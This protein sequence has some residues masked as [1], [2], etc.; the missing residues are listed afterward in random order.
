MNKQVLSP[1]V[2]DMCAMIEDITKQ[3]IEVTASDT[4]IRLSWAQ[5]G[6]DG[7]DTPEAQ[8]IEALKQAIRGRLGDRFIEFF[9]A[10]GIQ[11]VY[12]KYDPEEYPEEMR[13]R[14]VG[15]DATA[16]T[17]Y[18]RTLLEVDAIQVRRD[19]LDDLLRFT[20]GGIIQI[21][22][23][24][25]GLAVYSFPTENGVMLDVPEGNFI[26]LA[27]DGKFGKMDMQ[28]FMANFEE[29]DANTAG[30]T[31]DEKR[32]FEKMNKLF[33]KNFQ[34]RFLKL[35]EEY[36]ELFVVADDMLVN[37]IIPENTSEIIDELADL[38]AV[39]FHI[40][41]LFGYSQKELQE[42]A[43]KKIAGREKNPDFMRKHPH[44][45]PGKYVCENCNKFEIRDGDDGGF[46]KEQK[47]MKIRNCLSCNQWQERQTA[48][49]YKHFY[50]RFNKRL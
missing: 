4:S 13:T 34:M 24:P 44:T 11:S 6:S 29:K 45:E 7:N 21:P 8:R 42:M 23:T 20:G 39:L 10:D 2:C 22:R 25:G 15:P 31:F 36:H 3:E 28:T 1:F 26:V 16:G 12:M 41:A 33:G 9:Y 32:L 38:N 5:N 19:N 14:L 17:R 49:E 46:C 48:E 37:G 18:C 47:K 35:T 43:Y 40:A 30:L 50:E 27:P